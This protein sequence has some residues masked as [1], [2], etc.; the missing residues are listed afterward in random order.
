VSSL[1]LTERSAVFSDDRVYRY[2]LTRVWSY[3]G[4]MLNV[5]GLNPSTA[6]ETVDDPTIRRCIAF[7]K[8]WG[9]IGLSMTNL[10]AFRAT[11]P[12]DLWK[13]AEPA[14][15]DNDTWLRQ[16]AEAAGMVLAAWGAN[17]M[18]HDA[19]IRTVRYVLRGIPL[20]CLGL[21]QSGAPRHPLY[22]PK[23]TLPVPFEVAS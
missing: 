6:D 15:P 20:R 9:Y 8:S 23:V 18:A 16:E 22:V 14:G 13:A 4:Q 10:C 11:K 5:I 12:V 19:G 1:A 3:G 2:R 17:I 21:T 7:A